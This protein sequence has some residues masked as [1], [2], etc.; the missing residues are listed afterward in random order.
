MSLREFPPKNCDGYPTHIN[1]LN[2][3]RSVT[4]V[5]RHAAP[6]PDVSFLFRNLQMSTA[7]T[8]INEVLRN[9]RT[10]LYAVLDWYKF[11]YSAT[12]IEK[13]ADGISTQVP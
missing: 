12:K 7:Y 3:P 4:S 13:Q 8:S 1:A 10:E 11:L 2:N 9:Q 6:G 5:P